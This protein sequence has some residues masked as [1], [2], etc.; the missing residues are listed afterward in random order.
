MGRVSWWV[1]SWRP[2]LLKLSFC[3][4]DDYYEYGRSLEDDAPLSPNTA[5][6]VL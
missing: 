4:D 2:L 6:M 1:C 3:V 5:G